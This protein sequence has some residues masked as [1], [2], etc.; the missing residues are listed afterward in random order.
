M[1]AFWL[2]DGAAG[3]RIRRRFDG[4]PRISWL[5]GNARSLAQPE[6]RRSAS[7]AR[8]AREQLAASAA[9]VR[10]RKCRMFNRKKTRNW[11]ATFVVLAALVGP[12]SA[13]SPAAASTEPACSA[14][15]ESITPIH[16]APGQTN[17]R[18]L[19]QAACPGLTHGS[20]RFVGNATQIQQVD[21]FDVGSCDMAGVA[22]LRGTP[23]SL[24]CITTYA[25]AQSVNGTA[26]SALDDLYHCW[27]V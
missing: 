9:S 26:S 24:V 20:I 25:I 5:D 10:E 7:A 15:L 3:H 11:L 21:C 22:E 1:A 19:G 6:H 17:L 18:A 13:A 12:L 27:P 23:G 14:L 4:L 8:P 2:I 16:V